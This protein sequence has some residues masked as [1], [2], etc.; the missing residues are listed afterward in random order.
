MSDLYT[1]ILKYNQMIYNLDKLIKNYAN[2]IVDGMDLDSLIEF[3]HDT[4]TEN[5]G[6]YSDAEL[7]EE[8]QNYD[9]DLLVEVDTV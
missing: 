1:E 6:N 4:I 8:I 9:P 7:I 2:S 5:L 3:A